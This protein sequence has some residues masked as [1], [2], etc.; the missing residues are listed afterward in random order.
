MKNTNNV[1][2]YK[3]SPQEFNDFFSSIM[4]SNVLSYNQPITCQTDLFQFKKIST[5]NLFTLWRGIKKKNKANPDYHGFTM[6][7][8][9]YT[10]HCPCVYE[11]LL[12]FINECIVSC[13]YPSSFKISTVIPLPKIPNPTLLAHYRPIS[14]QS[15]LSKLFEKA[16]H[17]QLMDYLETNNILYPAQFGFRAGH[18]TEDPIFAL[19]QVVNKNLNEGK[20]TAIV[21]LDM[22]KAFDKVHKDIVRDQS[23]YSASTTIGRFGR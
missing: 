14:L 4:N 2:E 6:K 9:S 10:I 23:L 18:S 19:S 8:L 5:P 7:M 1:H 22:Q 12:S 17:F 21:A 16:I 13:T 3:N 15:Q 11:T 20:F